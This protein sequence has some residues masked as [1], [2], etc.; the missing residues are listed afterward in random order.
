MIY[1]LI[2]L[3]LEV[4][5]SSTISGQI[6]GL[7]TFVEILL[8]VVIGTTILKNF[9]FSLSEKINAV[10]NGEITQDE[11]VKSSVGK[12]IG[13]IL[14]IVP[15]FFTDIIGILLQF[16]L[17]TIVF[18][19][20]FKFKPRASNNSNYSQTNYSYTEFNSYNQPKQK[21]EEDVIDV[22]IIDDNKSI[23]H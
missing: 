14:L 16:G 22:E 15:G 11:F 9:K 1:F 5:I 3:F 2:Y 12:A 8:T 21:G 6:G 18:S 23:K 7:L 20:I 10:K 13:A 17:F 4:M 19:K